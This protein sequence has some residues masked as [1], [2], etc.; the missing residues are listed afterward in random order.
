MTEESV[1]LSVLDQGGLEYGDEREISR[2]L[3]VLCLL[4]SQ[5]PSEGYLDL[6]VKISSCMVG[7]S[8][9]SHDVGVDLL[10]RSLRVSVA[11]HFDRRVMQ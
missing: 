3:L 6:W 5:K 10:R 7:H 11:S 9:A 4:L 8:R 2:G 1:V